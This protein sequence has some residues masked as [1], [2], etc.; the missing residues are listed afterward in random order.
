MAIRETG[1]AITPARRA[2]PKTG[3]GK[4]GGRVRPGARKAT[5]R[6]AAAGVKPRGNAL[7]FAKSKRSLR[8][9]GVKPTRGGMAQARFKAARRTGRG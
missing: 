5:K 4:L 1:R 8:R 7:A 9:K 2:V 6:P 3:V